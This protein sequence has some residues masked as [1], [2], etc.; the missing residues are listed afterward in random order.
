MELWDIYDGSRGLTGRTHRRG[1]PLGQGEFHL[2][3]EIWVINHSGQL[4][5]TQRDF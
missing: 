3:A 1:E 2:V 5:L 4:L